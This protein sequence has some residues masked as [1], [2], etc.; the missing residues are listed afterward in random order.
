M[1]F[2]IHGL[3]VSRGI[4]IG[5]AVVVASS[6]MEVVHY[7][8]RPDQV[9]S[10]IQRARTARNAVIDEPASASGGDAQGRA[11]RA[12]MRCSMCI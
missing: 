4:A 12:W 8:I 9:E 1:T 11:R 3:A 5:R 2:A 6:R 10:E 7:F